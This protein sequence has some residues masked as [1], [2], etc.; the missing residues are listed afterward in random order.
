MY[1]CM[2]VFIKRVKARNHTVG[3]VKYM[4]AISSSCVARCRSVL[5]ALLFLFLG[6]IVN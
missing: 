1:A 5:L 2:Y 4:G 6:R 3:E